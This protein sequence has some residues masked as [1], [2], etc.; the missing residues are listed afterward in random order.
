MIALR[1]VLLT[2]NGAT[3]LLLVFA[4]SPPNVLKWLSIAIL[5]YFVLDFVY[6]S[7]TYPQHTISENLAR[8]KGEKVHDNQIGRIRD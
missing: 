1:N 3:F 7:L 8:F 4:G 2:I 6:L 5:I